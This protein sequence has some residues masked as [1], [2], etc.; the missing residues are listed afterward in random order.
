MISQKVIG[1]RRIRTKPDGMGWV[2]HS[3]KSIRVQNA[4]KVTVVKNNNNLQLY[5][6]KIGQNLVDMLRMIIQGRSLAKIRIVN[7]P[8]W[9]RVCTAYKIYTTQKKLRV[10]NICPYKYKLTS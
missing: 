3:D 9:Q 7:G 2:R 4:S 6:N 5:L 10:K 8:A 1:P